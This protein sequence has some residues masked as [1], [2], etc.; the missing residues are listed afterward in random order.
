MR[1]TGAS[2]SGGLY[3][4]GA[5][6]LVAPLLGWHLES[7]SLAAAFGSLPVALKSGMKFLVAWPFVFHS[8]NGVR[9]LMYDMALGYAKKDIVRYGWVLWGISALG[10]LGLVAFV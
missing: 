7:A 9:H 10:A 1:I 8:V 2:L 6:Y 3:I 5:A 4:F